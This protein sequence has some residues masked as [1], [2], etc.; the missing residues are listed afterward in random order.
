MQAYDT[1]GDHVG[2]IRPDRFYAYADGEVAFA[3]RTERFTG[4]L[5]GRP[6]YYVYGSGY[7]TA[8]GSLGQTARRTDLVGEI[9][10]SLD[11]DQF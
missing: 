7:G 8:D 9:K 3:G 6:V 4:S 10:E 1:E 2:I 5:S 11:H